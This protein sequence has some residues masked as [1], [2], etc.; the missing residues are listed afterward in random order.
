[1]KLG[2]DSEQEI[3]GAVEL[4]T[5]GGGEQLGIDEGLGVGQPPLYFAH[6]D[7][8]LVIA[9][10]AAPVF[11]VGFLEKWGVARL[12]VTVLLVGDTPG[13]ILFFM[14]VQATAIKS[15]LELREERFISAKK[16]RLQQ[17][18]LGSQVAVGLRNDFAHRARG[19]TD[20]KAN[21]P[22]HI[23]HMLD[24]IGDL[25]GRLGAVRLVKKKNVDVAV[26]IEFAATKSAHGQK[27]NRGRFVDMRAQMGFP[28]A[29]PKVTKHDGDD[30]GA[31]L[32]K[33]TPAL[34]MDMFQPE[35]ML[36]KLEKSAVDVE[37]VGR[38]QMG[39]VD[40]FA[41]CV[42]QDFF[43]VDRRHRMK[44]IAGVRQFNG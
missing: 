35:A 27:R 14:S 6:P 10:A 2:A 3:V 41:F 20:L 40:Q 29:V 43:E 8:I 28:G 37:Q 15:F 34:A 39:L 11:D 33:V 9:Q 23:E 4:L 21:V 42:A 25:G 44:L 30:I 38:S 32:A 17:R 5:L 18:G 13:E 31:L 7:K 24:D 16:A 26:G 12:V 19:V 36:L 22:Q 1:M